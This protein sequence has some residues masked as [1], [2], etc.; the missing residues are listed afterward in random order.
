MIAAHPRV[1]A[2]RAADSAWPFGQEQ[3]FVPR[4]PWRRGRRQCEDNSLVRGSPLAVVPYS[5]PPFPITTAT[6]YA[7]SSVPPKLQSSVSVH[8]PPGDTGGYSAKTVPL[9]KAPPIEV[10]TAHHC[11]Q[12]RAGL[13]RT[14]EETGSQRSG[15]PPAEFRRT[16]KDTG[17]KPCP[18]TPNAV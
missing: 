11:D 5:T 13:D 10:D 17:T 9:L 18:R 6:G 12:W 16:T 1:M 8:A 15:R 7:P 3:S 2:L 4:A 14:P